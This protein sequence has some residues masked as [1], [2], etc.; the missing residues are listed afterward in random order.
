MAVACGSDSVKS[1]DPAVTKDFPWLPGIG[2]V[3]P[4]GVVFEAFDGD[5]FLEGAQE[6]CGVRRG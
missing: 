3:E 5:P 2:L 1:E 4:V 6:G